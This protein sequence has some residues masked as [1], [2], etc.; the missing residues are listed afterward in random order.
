MCTPSSLTLSCIATSNQLF[1]GELRN[2]L[3]IENIPELKAAGVF[4]EAPLA[5]SD[6]STAALLQK[7]QADTTPDRKSFQGPPITPPS[8]AASAECILAADVASSSNAS[9]AGT[10]SQQ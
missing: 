4:P 7:E 10:E 3:A 6:A 2:T 5:I 8:R 1:T 9:L